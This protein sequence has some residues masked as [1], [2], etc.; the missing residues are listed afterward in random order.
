[1]T[2]D[3]EEDLEELE[4]ISIIVLVWVLS[5]LLLVDIVI[6]VGILNDVIILIAIISIL[7]III[8]IRGGGVRL[9]G[10]RPP[11]GDLI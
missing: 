11:D 2:P 3:A 4:E 6:N 7:I 9:R 5:W 1:M 8:V 10:R